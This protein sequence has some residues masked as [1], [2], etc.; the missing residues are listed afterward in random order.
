MDPIN[1]KPYN[2]ILIT[3]ILIAFFYYPLVGL[4]I[5]GIKAIPK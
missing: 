4:F 1:T 2:Y 3:G 5:S